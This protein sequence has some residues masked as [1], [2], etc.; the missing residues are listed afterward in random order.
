MVIEGST[1]NELLGLIGS[2]KET[3]R[4]E[5]KD[6]TLADGQRVHL[7][8]YIGEEQIPYIETLIKELLPYNGKILG[9]TEEH[10]TLTK[11]S[12]Y[13]FSRSEVFGILIIHIKP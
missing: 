6:G 12:G 7:R 2:V 3:I 8:N 9:Y 1:N 4:S 11:E 5:I 10:P 13:T